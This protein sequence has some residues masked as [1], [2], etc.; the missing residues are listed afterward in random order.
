VDNTKLYDITIIGAGPAGMTAAI[1]AGR[2]NKSV[3]IIDKDGFG[4]QIVKSPK[5]E[6]YP[7]FSSISGVDLA[8]NMYEQMCSLETVEHIIDE[9]ILVKYLRGVFICYF[10]D[11]T[12]ICSKSLIIAT[13]STHKTLNL[14]TPNLYYCATCDGPFFKN[15]N[16]IVVG[17]GNTGATY[18]L[19]LASYCKHVYIC[20]TTFNLMCEASLARQ[21]EAKKDKITFLPN[22]TIESV[23]NKDDKLVSITLDTKETIKVSAIFGAIGTIPQ[24]EFL[25]DQF[26]DKDE[27]GYIISVAGIVS[28]IPGLFVA[29]DCRT[30]QVKQITT[31]VADGTFTAVKAIKFINKYK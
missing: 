12:T 19:E 6:N 4:G 27:Y 23:E 13:G 22:C 14:N 29:G 9:V 17:S 3:A 5:I 8:T 15:K 28:K 26:V 31:A 2:S 18:A 21:I 20:D 24:T 11:N 7:G 16:V 25:S 1:Y 30:S 10:A